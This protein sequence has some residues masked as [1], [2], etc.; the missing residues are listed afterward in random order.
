MSKT[1]GH[2]SVFEW[3]GTAIAGLTKFG[4][5][6]MTR[7]QVDATDMD[8]TFD[9]ILA[10]GYIK[11]NGISIEGFFDS[12]DEGQL[13]LE[14]D[15]LSGTMDDFG[16]TM[17]NAAEISAASSLITAYKIGDIEKDGYIP[18]SATVKPNGAAAINRIVSTGLTTPFFAVSESG[19]IVPAPSG[20]V[21]KYTV[22]FATE[23]TGI[24][25]T[26]TAS[27]GVITIT[28]EDGNSQTVTSGLAS[29]SIALG[30]AGSIKTVMIAVKETGKVPRVYTLDLVRASA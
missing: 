11:T 5:I 4:G 25:I 16:I 14:A 21:T 1:I 7:D 6:D 15:F 20:S 29:T 8:S 18:F 24:T 23:I 26:P 19:V 9:E 28:D 13:A 10:G 22:N 12:A 2:G 30:A 17:P 3:G 27:A